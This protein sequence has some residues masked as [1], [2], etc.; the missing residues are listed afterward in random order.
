MSSERTDI[1]LVAGGR[2]YVGRY[3]IVRSGPHKGTG[4]D[5]LVYAR[6]KYARPLRWFEQDDGFKNHYVLVKPVF[7]HPFNVSAAIVDVYDKAAK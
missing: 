5:V 3:V 7:G 2:P 4:G 6:S 1:T